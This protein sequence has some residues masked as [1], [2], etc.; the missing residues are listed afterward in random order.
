MQ[1]TFTGH[2]VETSEALREFISDKLAKMDKF[3]RINK[4]QVILRSEPKGGRSVEVVCHLSGGK[5]LVATARHDDTYA[6][7][8]LVSDKVQRQLS[9][10]QGQRR[11]RRDNVREARRIKE[12]M[13]A[14]GTVSDEED[15][16]I[17]EEGQ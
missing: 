11:G 2:G 12:N 6:A 16:F 5:S 14:V 15:E 8:D 9:K 17:E 4:V 1:I 3:A 13:G 7:V 10:I